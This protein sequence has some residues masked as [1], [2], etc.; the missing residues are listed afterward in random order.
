MFHISGNF[1]KISALFIPKCI[2]IL[3]LIFAQKNMPYGYY[4]LMRYVLFFCFVSFLIEE[5]TE[6]YLSGGIAILLLILFVKRQH[7]VDR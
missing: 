4:S 5:K 3:M 6:N 7:K 1:K 2:A